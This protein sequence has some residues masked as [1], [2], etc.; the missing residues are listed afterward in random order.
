M[1]QVDFLHLDNS[2]S[3]PQVDTI[4]FEGMTRKV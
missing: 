2:Q 1:D 4:A 3:F